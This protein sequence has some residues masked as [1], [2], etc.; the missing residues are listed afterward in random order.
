VN[1]G[2]L[3]CRPVMYQWKCG[4]R[5]VLVCAC[6]YEGAYNRSCC[7]RSVVVPV[8]VEGGISFIRRMHV[9]TFGL[10]SRE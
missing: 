2:V 1:W 10:E 5:S 9:I 6:W 4:S 8:A 7:S 3:M